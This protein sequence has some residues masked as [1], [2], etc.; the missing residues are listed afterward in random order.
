MRKAARLMKAGVNLFLL[1]LIACGLTAC[2]DGRQ[3]ALR[4]AAQALVEEAPAE[5]E[6]FYQPWIG[7]EEDSVGL[8]EDVAKEL[9]RAGLQPWSPRGQEMRLDTTAALLQ[10]SAITRSPN[11]SYGVEAEWFMPRADSRAYGADWS[12]EVRCGF[13]CE[14]S[15]KSVAHSD[16]TIIP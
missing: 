14:V 5:R 3:K 12:L 11:G 2:R 4:V 1:L 13:K 9:Q 8:G 16:Y 6:L 15:R 7:S 10:F